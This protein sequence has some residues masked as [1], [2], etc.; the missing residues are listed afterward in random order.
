[1]AFP[2]AIRGMGIPSHWSVY[3]QVDDVD[4]SFAKVT[5]LGGVVHLPPMDIANVGRIAFVGEPQGVAFGLITPA[6][7]W[8]NAG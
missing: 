6:G 7:D 4:A 5:S 1:M 2:E 3:F 8:S